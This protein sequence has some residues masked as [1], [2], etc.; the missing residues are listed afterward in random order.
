MGSLRESLLIALWLQREQMEFSQTFVFIQT[1]ADR[2]KAKEAFDE[3]RKT[4]FPW[5]E[6]SKEKRKAEDIKKLMEEVKRG[7]LAIT[8]MVSPKLRSRLKAKVVERQ[9]GGVKITKEQ[10]QIYEKIGQTIPR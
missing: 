2:S 5:I 7:A 10:Q 3:Y 4:R 8:P 9:V 1:M 6:S